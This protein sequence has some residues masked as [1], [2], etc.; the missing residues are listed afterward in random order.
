M[1]DEGAAIVG[2]LHGWARIAVAG[3]VAGGQAT[4]RALRRAGG[5]VLARR[6]KPS[7]LAT[8]RLLVKAV[9]R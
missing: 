7:K 5:D 4:V 6:A 3:F 1:L 8:V 2:R 9:A